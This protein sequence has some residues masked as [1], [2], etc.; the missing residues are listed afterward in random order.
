M[1][2]NNYFTLK[3]WFNFLSS[4]SKE[5]KVVAQ[6]FISDRKMASEL[7]VSLDI[8]LMISN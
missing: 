8:L 3:H 7:K 2:K 4:I 6:L 1:H 5:S